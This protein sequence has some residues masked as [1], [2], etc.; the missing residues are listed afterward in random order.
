MNLNELSIFVR[1]NLAAFIISLFVF[2]A[3]G[4]FLVDKYM[5]L[6]ESRVKLEEKVKEFYTDSLNKEKEFSSRENELYKLEVSLRSEKE[7]YEKKMAELEDVKKYYEGLNA[8]LNEKARASSVAIRKQAVEDKLSTLMSEF[9]ALG[10]NL[11]QFPECNDKDGW[12]Q[13]NIAKAKLS[14]MMSFANANGLYQDYQGFFIEN[15]S[16][17]IVRC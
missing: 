14:E 16:S 3:F 15:F 8:E 6:Y 11:R 5:A 12:R 7:S 4:A 2:G 10:V 9:T 13:Y 17:V 1:K